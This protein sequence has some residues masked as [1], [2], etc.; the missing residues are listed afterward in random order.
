MSQ[1]EKYDSSFAT[2]IEMIDQFRLN[3]YQ[4]NCAQ[5]VE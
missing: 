1:N 2:G 4:P 5:A 3:P